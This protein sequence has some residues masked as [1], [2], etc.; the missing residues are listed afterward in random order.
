MDKCFIYYN[1][2]NYDITE[3]FYFPHFLDE[4]AKT[5]ADHTP[6]PISNRQ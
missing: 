6:F 1:P 3:Y 4:E 2:P 5:E